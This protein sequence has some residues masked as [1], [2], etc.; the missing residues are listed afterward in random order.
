MLLVYW[1]TLMKLGLAHYDWSFGGIK[2]AAK[3][4]ILFPSNNAI[5]T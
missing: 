3:K 5:E 2:L 1:I 4:T